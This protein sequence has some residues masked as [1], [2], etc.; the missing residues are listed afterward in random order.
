MMRSAIAAAVLLASHVAFA[1]PRSDADKLFDEGLKLFDAGKYDEACAK[2]EQSIAKDPRAV[3][4]LMNLARCNERRGK[5]ATALALFQEAFD[6]AVEANLA[7]ARDKAKERIAALSAQVPVIQL[8][9][10]TAPLPNEKLVIDDKVVA[11]GTTELR[12]DPGAHTLV[13]TA[14]GRLPYET[15][16]EARAGTQ[17]VQLREPEAPAS[18]TD[19][20]GSTGPTGPTGAMGATVQPRLEPPNRS[21]KRVGQGLVLGGGVLAIGAGVLAI[22]A[23]RDYDHQFVDPDGDGPLLA[24]CGSFPAI[25]GKPACNVDGQQHTDRDRTFGVAATIL[26]AAG[27]AIA[28]AG[29]Y[30]WLT[31]PSDGV[32][33]VP[34]GTG[35]ALVGRF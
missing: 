24:P 35:V 17:T 14:P 32:A 6:R 34:T 8:S 28:G 21:R 4:T 27:I 11:A 2:F 9:R 20:T 31:A 25:N 23:K 3:G 7:A 26:G 19:P 10:A 18:T 30:L 1:Q 5:T 15:T 13:L 29:V 22:V 16:F 12:L 33:V